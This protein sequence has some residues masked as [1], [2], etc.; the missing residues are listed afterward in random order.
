MI[1]YLKE[2][3]KWGGGGVAAT[4]ENGEQKTENR[5]RG[6]RATGGSGGK[7]WKVCPAGLHRRTSKKPKRGGLRPPRFGEGR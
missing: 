5:A 1:P 6:K 2:K 4:P 7:M 3:G